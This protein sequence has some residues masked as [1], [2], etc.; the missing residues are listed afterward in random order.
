MEKFFFF[1]WFFIVG[2]WEKRREEGRKEEEGER[3]WKSA[4][5]ENGFCND[6]VFL[7][8]VVLGRSE[9]AS[10]G[11][12]CAGTTSINAQNEWILPGK[13]NLGQNYL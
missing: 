12:S 11:D 7:Q 4:S 6:I 5:S 9:M 8:N 3:K 1:F 13:S 2:K 10:N